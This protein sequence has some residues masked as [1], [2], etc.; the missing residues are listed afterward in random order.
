[1][2]SILYNHKGIANIRVTSWVTNQK[3]KNTLYDTDDVFAHGWLEAY[4]L[5]RAVSLATVCF[6]AICFDFFIS[7]FLCFAASQMLQS[8][9][10]TRSLCCLK[11]SLKMLKTVLT[12]LSANSLLSREVVSRVERK[13][14]SNITSHSLSSRILQY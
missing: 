3:K 9:S 8:C 7:S 13:E 6:I 12:F 11:L 1:M 4:T 2:L 14:S 5:S 10:S